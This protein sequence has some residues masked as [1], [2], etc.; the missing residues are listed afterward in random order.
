MDIHNL[1]LDDLETM[2]AEENALNCG[3]TQDDRRDPD[4]E[5]ARISPEEWNAGNYYAVTI[6]ADPGDAS[7]AETQT[8]T[9]NYDD[10]VDFRAFIH[11]NDY[12]IVSEKFQTREEYYGL[13]TYEEAVNE[14]MTADERHLTMSHFPQFSETARIKVHD[15][16]VLAADTGAGKSSLAINFLNDLNTDYPVLYFN[17]EMDKLTVLRR[18]V[19]IHTGM[20]LDKIEGYQK[21]ANTAAQVNNALRAITSRKPLQIMQNVYYLEEMEKVIAK[22]TE[23]RDEPTIVIIDHSLLVQSKDPKYNYDRYGRFTHIS[24]E[25]R[26]IS[27]LYNIVLFI[28]CQQNREGKKDEEKPPTNSSLKESGSWE[29][30]ATQIMFLWKD[31]NLGINQRL[32]VMT[33]NRNGT[34]GNF[35]LNYVPVTQTYSEAKDQPQDAANNGFRAYPNTDKAGKQ[36]SRDKSRAKWEAAI[37]AAPKTDDGRTSWPDI[38]EAAGVSVRTV[39]SWAKEFGGVIVNGETITPAGINDIVEYT[40]FAPFTPS[41]DAEASAAFQEE[42][43]DEIIG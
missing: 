24:E 39:K 34:A 3:D 43:E 8:T 26:R 18:L 33:K 9:G 25:L 22:N 4:H 41:Q 2:A 14:F 36:T 20:K 1:E 31:P 10:Y 35:I 6:K 12:F 19:A 7:K 32:L 40:G 15:S 29:N 16:V 17:L 21:D 28:L 13:L 11:E 5:P 42:E 38:A 30:D 27:R 37:K 23:D